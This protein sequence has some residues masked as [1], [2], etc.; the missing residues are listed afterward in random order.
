MHSPRS[1]RRSLAALGASAT[2]ASVSFVGGTSTAS[3]EEH[4]GHAMSLTCTMEFSAEAWSVFVGG[5]RG[6]GH[7]RCDNG[8]EADVV[9]KGESVGLSVG[10]M[11]VSHGKGIFAHL[12][13]IDEV[14]GRYAAD[15]A[16]AAAGKGAAAGGLVKVDSKVAL[17]F[18][19]TGD[20]GGGLIRNWSLVTIEREK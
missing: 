14:Y 20:Q 8:Q 16:G 1:T 12:H 17:A 11:K 10:A 7:V 15:S 18:A 6:K 13:D 3:A 9:I 2:L 19:A 4:A 5:E